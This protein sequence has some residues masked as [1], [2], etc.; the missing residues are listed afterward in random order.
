MAF[1]GIERRKAN[2]VSPTGVERRALKAGYQGPDKAGYRGALGDPPNAGYQGSERRIKSGASPT[3]KERRLVAKQKAEPRADAK[4]SDDQ[5]P[6]W[7]NDQKPPVIANNAEHE[8]ELLGAKQ[9]SGYAGQERRVKAGASPTG[10]ER[11][12]AAK[13]P[14]SKAPGSQAPAKS[15]NR[16]TF[17]K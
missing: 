8:K 7:L 16:V 13:I 10:R 5:Y 11:R 1:T 4:I 6:K 15:V 9:K 17:P 2:G 3:G 12:L 14:A